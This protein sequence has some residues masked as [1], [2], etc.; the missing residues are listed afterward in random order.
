MQQ[1]TK[2]ISSTRFYTDAN[3]PT[4]ATSRIHNN[5]NRNT[6]KVVAEQRFSIS[7]SPTPPPPHP[8]YSSSSFSLG[9]IYGAID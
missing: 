6:L 7:S 5:H 9:A 3:N 4:H 2:T 1:A 8:D